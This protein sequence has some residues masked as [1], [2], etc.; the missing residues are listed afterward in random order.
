[1]NHFFGSKYFG[2]ATIIRFF[3]ALDWG[4]SMSRIRIIAQ[5]PH[6]AQKSKNGGKST[7]FP[8]TASSTSDNSPAAYVRELFKPPK[9]SW[10]LAV[11][12]EKKT[13]EIR[14]WVFGGC[15]QGWDMF[16]FLLVFLLWRHHPDNEQKLWLKVCLDPTL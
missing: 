7:S 8:L 9:N 15:R 2:N 4:F 13:F 3:R 11:W 12:T 1:M 5:T 16:C 6:F 14:I 10:S